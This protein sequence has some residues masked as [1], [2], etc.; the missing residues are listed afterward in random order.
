MKYARSETPRVDRNEFFTKTQLKERNWTD[1]SIQMF[2]HSYDSES[3]NPMYRSAPT[4]KLYLQE[5]V[6]EAEK[7][8]EFKLWLEK[9]KVRKISAQKAVVT[10]EDALLSIVNS[11]SIKIEQCTDKIIIHSAVNDYNYFKSSREDFESFA[12]VN[13]DKS[14]LNRIVVNYLRHQLTEYDNKLD[15][16]AGKVGVD[17]AYLLLNKK[18]YTK[19]AETY[20][21]Y[22]Q[23]CSNQLDRKN[24]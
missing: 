20:P 12:T 4:V 10:K 18:I 3:I 14:F 8:D 1:A 13:S 7:L 11:W 5:R 19:I 21:K 24:N 2:L 22:K 6:K 17:K 23:E 15:E 16:I 9:S